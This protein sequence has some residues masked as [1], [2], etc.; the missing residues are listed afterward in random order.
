MKVNQ[1]YHKMGKVR[2]TCACITYLSKGESVLV[3]V[4]AERGVGLVHEAKS[5][6]L[7]P[8]S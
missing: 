8:P 7:F 3:V 2:S 1:L 6:K 5:Y 4:V